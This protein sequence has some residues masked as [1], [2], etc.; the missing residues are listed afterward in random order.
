MGRPTQLEPG[1]AR[2]APEPLAVLPSDP[3]QCGQ[4]G[5]VAFLGPSLGS[6]HGLENGFSRVAQTTNRHSR[7]TGYI[8]IQNLCASKDTVKKV[9][10]QEISWGFGG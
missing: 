6:R 5:P 1:R 3:A 8:Q 2:A 4:Q 9:K 10:I 7:Y